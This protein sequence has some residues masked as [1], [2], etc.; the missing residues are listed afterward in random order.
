MGTLALGTLALAGAARAAERANAPLPGLPWRAA[1]LDAPTAAAHL[2]DRFAFGARPGEVDEVVAMGLDTW[3]EQQLRGLD[4]PELAGRLAKLPSLRLPLDRM[5]ERYRGPAVLRRMMVRDGI[6]SPTT[7]G[8][9]DSAE[10]A[11]NALG[12]QQV[13]AYARKHGLRPLRRLLGELYSQKLLRAV[14][15]RNELREVL[16]DF[17]FNHLNVSLRD[18]EVRPYVLGYERD[19]IRPHVLG[20]FRALLGASARHPAMLLF[21][22]NARSAVEPGRPRSFDLDGYRWRRR[23]RRAAKGN[24]SPPEAVFDADRAWAAR[25]PDDR[26][27]RGLNENYAR[28]LMELH[29]LGADGGYTEHDVREVARAFTGWSIVPPQGL[30]GEISARALARLCHL[31]GSKF[32]RD[33]GFLFRA[34][35]HDAGEKTVLGER[36]A[37]GRGIEDGEQ[38]LDLL[39]RHPSTARHVARKLATR[40]VSDQPPAALVATLA[41]TF[42]DTDGD[43]AAMIR[44]L[45]HAPAFWS[46]QARRSKIKTPFELAAS[47]LR[48]LNA[49]VAYAAPL[50]RR[51]ARIGQQVYA[52]PDPAGFPDRATAWVSAGALLGRMNLGLDLAAGRV[53][54]I[55]VDLRGLTGG[56]EPD[57]AQAALEAYGRAFLPGR[58]IPDTLERL[59]RLAADPGVASREP[60][61]PLDMADFEADPE[62][63][64]QATRARRDRMLAHIAGLILGSPAFQRR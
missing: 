53:A 57:S 26:R 30:R 39:S 50:M 60:D 4:D 38:V 13:D 21:L 33:Q 34:D 49:D 47:A 15:A 31:P 35:L 43:L 8:P 5:V 29:T 52:H 25:H 20:R 37:A 63:P 48:A 23:M 7:D 3:L 41:A 14:Y 59:A 2:L 56:L 46:E 45:A 11:D 51:L 27:P 54:G 17:W 61:E 18:A 12:R 55:R 22:D 32:V 9:G 44:T 40:F 24:R 58:E 64:R 36:L 10:H 19:A 62:P 42:L 16:T 28:E 1:G 6:A